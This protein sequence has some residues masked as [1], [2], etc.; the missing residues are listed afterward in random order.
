MASHLVRR[1]I[2]LGAPG[3]GKS[4]IA[5]RIVQTYGMSHIVVGDLVR[6]HIQRRSGSLVKID[7]FNKIF[8][9]AFL[10][11]SRTIRESTD[12]GILLPDDVVL[13]F[14][15]DEL[16]RIGEQSCL[17]DGNVRLVCYVWNYLEYV[18]CLIPTGYPR[19]LSQAE[20]FYRQTKV[21]HVIALNVSVDEIIN[22]LQDRW[23]HLSSGRVYHR[24]WNPPKVPV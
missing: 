6:Q 18:L 5:N 13:K 7:S 2:V 21:D 3:S 1:L 8:L 4:T 10:D 24:L 22:R 17:L 11:E 23:C 16:T 15:T 20:M 9:D 14:V 12:K 19:T